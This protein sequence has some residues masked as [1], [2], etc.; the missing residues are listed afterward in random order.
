MLI[1]IS[2]VAGSMPGA[3]VPRCEGDGAVFDSQE[4]EGQ[5]GQ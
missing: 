5:L 2:R 3:M 1:R 4:K